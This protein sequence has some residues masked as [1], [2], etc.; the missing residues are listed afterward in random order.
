MRRALAL[1][2]VAFVL[3]GCPKDTTTTTTTTTTTS[4]TLADTTAPSKPGGVA[5]TATSCAQIRV[6]WNASTDAGSGVEG[7]DVRRGGVPIGHVVAPATAFD[8][9]GRA[10]QTSYAYTV[11]ARDHAG[12][13]S[14]ASASASAT[15][16]SCTNQPPVAQAGPD[17]FTQTLMPVAFDGSASSDPGG[18]IATYAWSFG[19]GASATGLTATHTYT[20]PGA[21]TVRLTVTDS[22]GLSASDTA[23]VNAANRAPIAAA[24]PD[25]GG[26]PGQSLAFSGAGSSDPDGTITAYAWTFGDGATASGASAAHAYAAAGTYT[27]RLT[28]TDDSGAQASDTAVVT[29]GTTW[30]RAFGSP[31]D[32]RAQ[33]VAV[34][35]SGEVAVAGAFAG[36]VDF[37]T[38]PLTSEHFPWADPNAAKDAFVARYT[39]SGGPLWARRVGA[40][41]D[42]RANAVGVDAGGNVVVAGMVANYVDLGDGTV[43]GG[44]GGFDGFVAVYAAAD[45]AHVWSRRFG[46]SGTDTALALAVDP[47]GNVLVAGTFQGTVDLGGGPLVAAGGSSDQ[48]L[49]VAKYT[50]AG[51]HVWSRRFGGVA[52]DYANG[53]AATSGG[54]VLLAGAFYDNVGFGG[55]SLAS[56]GGYDA[57]LVKLAG[58]NAAHVWSKRFGAA[59]DD[60]AFAVAVDAGGNA[61]MAGEFRNSVNFGGGA[62]ASAGGSDAFVASFASAGTHRWSRRMGGTG[63]DAARGVAVDAAANVLLTGGFAGTADF[64]GGPLTAVGGGDLVVARYAPAN[65]AHQSSR[66][67]GGP[68]YQYGTAIAASGGSAAIAGYF[69]GTIDLGSGA[70]STAGAFDGLVGTVAP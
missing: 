48:D 26:T 42:D 6:T 28:V 12:N 64:G 14:A 2:W 8:D 70:V 69:E 25:K 49:F 9:P 11:S 29:V 1:L 52:F 17:V 41:A 30:S 21:H 37:G 57:F 32:D 27:A 54:D 62:F 61:V 23:T 66:R 46:S 5:A 39:A 47:A 3:A 65:G 44:G 59:A 15:T 67:F 60:R 36:T 68:G 16:P 33:G 45:G 50:S 10:A 43:T 34:G 24:G 31:G 53:V 35:P 4:T 7:Y 58:A 51:A 55:P 56:A 20:T 18:G 38:G 19:D 63:E 40:E 13:V 22:G